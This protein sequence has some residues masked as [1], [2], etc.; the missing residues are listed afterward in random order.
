MTQEQQL[1]RNYFNLGGGLNTEANEINF[2][3]GFTIDEANYELLRDG[4]RRRRKGLAQESGA[5]TD[6][7]H[8]NLFTG[9]EY[10]QTYVW[11]NVAGDPDTEF[12]VLRVGDFMYF[13]PADETISDGWYTGTNSFIY[14]PSFNTTGATTANRANAPVTFAQG[15]GRLLVCGQYLKPFYVEWD[16]VNKFTSSVINLRARDFA[17]IDDGTQ[18]NVEPTDATI[19]ADHNYNLRNRGWPEDKITTFETTLSKWPARNSIWYKGHKRTYG[20]SIAEADGTRSWDEN[21]LDAEGF[22]LSSAPTG[23]LFLNPHDTTKGVTVGT[24]T[25]AGGAITTW[26]AVIPPG[27][28]ATWAV[29]LTLDTTH[30][31]GVG[32]DFTITGHQM[33]LTIEI[34]IYGEGVLVDVV[35]SFDGTHT[36]TT[37]TSG[38]TV[39]FDYVF[40]P[41]TGQ[42]D[43]WVD[44]YKALGSVGGGGVALNRSIGTAHT[45]SWAAVGWHAGRAWFAGMKN[46]E[47]NDTIFFSQIVDDD[48]RYGLCFQE[49]D[50]T[51]ENFN[52]LVNTDGGSIV[53]PGMGG[54]VA[55]RSLRDSLLIFGRDGI[56]AV[57]AGRGGFTPSSYVVRKLSEAGATSPDSIVIIEDSCV[58]TGPGGV[59]IISPAEFTGILESQNVI[60]ESIQSTWNEIP[61]A[62]QARV[63]G[64][65]DDAKRQF[66]LMYNDGNAAYTNQINTMLIFH[67]DVGSWSRYTFNTGLSAGL[68]T[69]VAVPQVDDPDAGKK[70]KFI[71]QTSDN[72]LSVADFSGTA[73]LDWDGNSGPAPYLVTGWSNLGDY[74]KPKQAPIVTVF[75]KRTETGYT[76]TGAGW[77]PVNPSSTTMTAAWDWVNDDTNEA[78]TNKITA[79]QEVYRHRRQFVPS[80]ATDLSGYPVVVTRNKLRGRGKVLALKFATSGTY[81]SHLL[82]FTVNYKATRRK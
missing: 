16:S 17:T 14:L 10:Y 31:L 11:R 62:N 58:Y 60:K 73:F 76:D 27:E 55:L 72:D 64:K 8:G 2:P 82:G 37:G 46:A 36:T 1:A 28:A 29:T 66:Y 74:A 30:G 49:A 32:E 23:S 42:F 18:V 19:P 9:S 45:D 4:S 48:F 24:V 52:A 59:Y 61:I 75:N 79:G 43:S 6:L 20:A 71:Y 56:W 50:P 78:D 53:I 26:T 35:A 65:Y 39:K 54:V 67:A 38:T 81:D 63:Q 25:T 57:E 15:R 70:M 21:K 69:G 34:D 44:Q 47:F 77:D 80:A 13:A 41:S 22:G 40:Q 33:E 68:M 12:L 3:D 7:V 5:G 51:D